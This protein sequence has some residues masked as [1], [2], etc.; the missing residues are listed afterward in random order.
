MFA[1]AAETVT[2]SYNT[3]NSG[4]GVAIFSAGFL[5]FVLGL[6]IVSVIALWKMFEKAKIDGWKAVVPIYNY[7]ILFEMAGKP[8]WWS[9]I[10]LAGV[11]P[12]LGIFAGIAAFI[13]YIIAALELGKAFKKSTA[14]TVVA[15]I[16]FSFVGLL[17][18]GFGKD[19]YHKPATAP[20]KFS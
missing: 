5:L 14:F 19:K 10:G 4:T 12:V 17:I 13:L 1:H 9:L 7:W 2:Y 8:G 18:L 15:L 11:I 3:T 20:A 6:W 16:I